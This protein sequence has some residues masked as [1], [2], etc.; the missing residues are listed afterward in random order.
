MRRSRRVVQESWRR[1]L[2]SR[3][4]LGLGLSCRYC[5]WDYSQQEPGATD[6][7][8]RI[9][10]FSQGMKNVVRS[11]R[12]LLQ[13]RARDRVIKT[14]A[15]TPERLLQLLNSIA[16]AKIYN[17]LSG[18]WL[19]PRSRARDADGRRRQGSGGGSCCVVRHTIVRSFGSPQLRAKEQCLMMMIERMMAAVGKNMDNKKTSHGSTLKRGCGGFLEGL[20]VAACT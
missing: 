19:M 5:R 8:P 20:D 13:S 16:I 3:S 18:H 4:R 11:E 15:S 17:R 14:E 2:A 7:S 9:W 1:A 12:W 10:H 6:S